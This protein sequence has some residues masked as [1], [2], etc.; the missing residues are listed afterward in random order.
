MSPTEQLIDFVRSTRLDEIDLEARRIVRTMITTVLGTTVAGAGE[1]GC[2]ELRGLLL[3]NGGAPQATSLV[4][5]DRLPAASAALLNGVMARALD[6]CD[7]MEP[8]LHLGSSLVPAALAAAEFRG[9]VSGEEFVT[10]VAVGAE[11]GSR[12]NLT[13]ALYDGLDPTGVVAP[14][15]ATATVG[16][17]LGLSGDQL[18]AALGLAFNRAGGSFQS[19]VDGSLAVRL[20]QGWAAEAGVTCALWA[21]RGLTGPHNFLDGVYGYTHLYG[22]GQVDAT[23]FVEELGDHYA[24]T[25]TMFKKYPSCGLTQGVTELALQARR[26]GILA[27]RIDRVEVVLPPYAYRLVGHPFAPGTNPRVDGQFSARF[28][29]A[30]AFLRGSSR[31]EHFTPTAVTGKEVG[32]LAARVHVTADPALDTRGHSAA[33]L[34]VVSQGSEQRFGLDI[35]PGFPGNALS[36]GYHDRRL[37]DCLAATA[38]P[39]PDSR[40]EKLMESLKALEELDD[41]TDLVADLIS[42]EADADRTA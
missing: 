42:P 10:A 23:T 37:R 8:G 7:A 32:D 13:E 12:L 41:V 27:D 35:A 29:V 36:Q 39:L 28:C 40:I 22:R 18:L 34:I 24:L 19:N 9:G 11:L 3:E 2:R 4:H 33:D 15:A 30:N 26:S 17:I 21:L 20:I 6:Y 16:R 31:L 38:Y 1:D 5:G 25:G 14:L